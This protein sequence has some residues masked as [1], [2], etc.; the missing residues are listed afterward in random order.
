MNNK[1]KTSNYI[2]LTIQSISLLLAVKFLT[3][4]LH[5]LGHC[6]GG[7]FV[8]LKPVGI[9]AGVLIF[10]VA[11]IIWLTVFGLT[12]ERAKGL[13]WSTSEEER[14]SACNIFISIKKDFRAQIDFLMRPSSRHLFWEKMKHQP[15]NWQI[16]TR[17]IETNLPILLGISDFK[18]IEQVDDVMS[19]FYIRKND[20]GARRIT[21]DTRLDTIIQT[22]NENSYALEI[23]DFWR[24]KGGYLEKLSISL[25]DGMKL[26]SYELTPE[27]T[28]EPDHYYE[29]E[30]V[31]ENKD[32]T[33]SEKIRLI[34]ACLNRGGKL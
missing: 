18:V 31:W 27:E 9:Y 34:F 24:I 7:W 10:S 26:S 13:L 14:V 25:E 29:Q 11:I 2:H 16:Y 28:K 30:I 22:I 17:F 5:E 1:I 12:E 32:V 6:L 23:T 15:P 4:I 19:P 8:G 3:T 21:I 33:A 20:T